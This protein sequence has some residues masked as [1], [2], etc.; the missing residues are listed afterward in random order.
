MRSCEIQRDDIIFV[1]VGAE[2][3]HGRT[4]PLNELLAERKVHVFCPPAQSILQPQ[5]PPI[6]Y[7][8]S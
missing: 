2:F 6:A 7:N 1:K 5:S 3:V 8:F 4:T